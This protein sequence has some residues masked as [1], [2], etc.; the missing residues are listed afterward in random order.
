[1]ESELTI[2]WLIINASF[3]T[4]WKICVES[5]NETDELAYGFFKEIGITANSEKSAK[6]LLQ[7]YLTTVNKISP[8]KIDIEYQHI[9]V[10][11]HDEVQTEIYEDK[12]INNSLL[13]SPFNEG[14]WYSSGCGFYDDK[15]S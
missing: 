2:Y 11:S 1:M 14:V 7:Q 8:S 10:I 5:D 13:Q 9:G 6:S 3:I 15:S 12:D 4:P